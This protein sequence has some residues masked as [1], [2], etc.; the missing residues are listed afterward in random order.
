MSR[1][2]IVQASLYLEIEAESEEEAFHMKNTIIQ[3]AIEVV[4]ENML[5]LNDDLSDALVY[6]W[7]G[8]IIVAQEVFDN[9]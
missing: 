4:S 1:D 9:E 3:K 5:S 6:E 8:P 7:S 2:Y